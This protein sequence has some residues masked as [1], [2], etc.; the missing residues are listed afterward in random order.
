MSSVGRCFLPRTRPTVGKTTPTSL[1]VLSSTPLGQRQSRQLTP[2]VTTGPTSLP[3]SPQIRPASHPHPSHRPSRA[4][5]DRSCRRRSFSVP[6]P[7]AAFSFALHSDTHPKDTRPRQASE[8]VDAA[9]T[10]LRQ[11][12][13]G[14]RWRRFDIF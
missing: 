10:P 4:D 8:R 13:F 12:Y 9:R 6:P 11:R 2:L 5:A 3:P 7:P 14:K 1:L